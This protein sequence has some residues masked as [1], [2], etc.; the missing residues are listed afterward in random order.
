MEQALLFLILGLC[1]GALAAWLITRYWLAARQHQQIEAALKVDYVHRELHESLQRQA[2]IFRDDLLDKEQELRQLGQQLAGL[3]QQNRHLE[4]KL[5][6][7]KASLQELQA[8]SRQEFTNIANKL[9]EEKSER[10]TRQNQQQ[11]DQI[12]SPL[13]EKIN[14]FELGIHQ[15]LREESA[16][17]ISLKKEIEQLRDLNQQLSQDANNLVNALKGESKTQG[18][19]GEVQLERLLEKAGLSRDIHFST[20]TSFKDAQGRDKRPDCL[21]H[22]PDQKHLII[23]SKVSL[24]AYEKFYN[25]PDEAQR[26]KHRKAH[27]ESVKRHIKDLS[28]K[29]YQQLY[30]INSPDYLLLYIPLEPAF[31][32]AM[33]EDQNLFLDALDKNIVIVTSSTLLATMRTVAFIWKQEKQKRS[34]LEIARQSGL[35]YDRFC[36][37]VE[38]LQGVGQRLDQAQSAY[39]AAMHKLTEA[40]RPGDTLIGR[41][42]KIRALG[43]RASYRL[44]RQLLD[45]LD[46]EE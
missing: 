27:L 14:A 28:S 12:L 35:L 15:R 25:D 41:A 11:L 42:E 26:S 22:L 13:K 45:H 9:L 38:D 44:P 29:N 19:W 34:V 33:Q 39:Q 4:E 17:R 31:G 23:D 5:N 2:D 21:I 16:D 8:Q 36:K 7:Q 43:A 1:L 18:D 24:V 46:E 30:Q 6:N 3:E 32:L 10:F 40:K 37:F 20:Q